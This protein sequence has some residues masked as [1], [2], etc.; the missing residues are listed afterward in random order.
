MN[1]LSIV[2]R[3]DARDRALFHRWVAADVSSPALLLWRAIT[4]L[5]GPTFTIGIVLATMLVG[6]GSVAGA[7]RH[8][9]I[10]LAF[11]HLIAQVIKR[12]VTRPRPSGESFEA[13]IAAPDRYSFPSGHAIA[14]SSIAFA[15]AAHFPALA[16]GLISLALI[17]GFSRI[18]LGVH[19]PGDV[20]VG[21]AIA[22]AGT[23]VVLAAL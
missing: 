5:G 2:A 16:P 9:A 19:Y 12:T 7:A 1:Q 3:L 18:R 23:A 21:Q 11:T 6:N 4:H 22:V 17:V 13:L 8:A 20:F 14:A 15:F 10:A